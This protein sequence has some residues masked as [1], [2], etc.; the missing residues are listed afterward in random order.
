[1]GRPYDERVQKLVNFSVMEIA[2]IGEATS[3]YGCAITDLSHARVSAPLQYVPIGPP[4]SHTPLGN[5][6]S[7]INIDQRSSSASDN[8]FPTLLPFPLLVT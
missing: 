4:C 5:S 1:M 2:G 7:G 6:G 3:F 8:A